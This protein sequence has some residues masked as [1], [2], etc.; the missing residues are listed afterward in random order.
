MEQAVPL[1]TPGRI[2]DLN[3][4]VVGISGENSKSL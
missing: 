3:S 2:E 4:M 1:L